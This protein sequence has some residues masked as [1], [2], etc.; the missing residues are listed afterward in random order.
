M[1][2]LTFVTGWFRRHGI[3]YLDMVL[4]ALE[5]AD[6]PNRLK[7]DP[8]PSGALVK[9]SDQYDLARSLGYMG[10]QG[11]KPLKALD[12]VVMLL[13]KSLKGLSEA[14]PEDFLSDAKWARLRGS[15]AK[16]GRDAEPLLEELR[17]TIE[18][19]R[20]FPSLAWFEKTWRG[21][22]R[23][24]WHVINEAP[25]QT[26]IDWYRKYSPLYLA[27]KSRVQFEYLDIPDVENPEAVTSAMYDWLERDGHGDRLLVNLW[28]TATAVQFGWY[29]LAWRR[30]ALVDAVFL[31]CWDDKSVKHARLAPITI[32]VVDK[33]PIGRLSVPVRRVT[34]ESDARLNAT[35]WLQFYLRQD[36]NFSIL[37]LGERGTGKSEAVGNAWKSTG[38]AGEVVVA[39]CANFSDATQA[40]S[41][42]FGHEKGAFTDA[43][44][45]RKG[46]LEQAD[47]GLLFLD[48]V[49]HLDRETRSMLLT[50]LQ[51]D[52][53]GRYS[54]T[55]LGGQ[56]SIHVRFQPVFASNCSRETL[57]RKLAP[58]FLDRIS[59][60]ILHWPSIAVGELAGVWTEVWDRMK[61]KGPGPKN[62]I[63]LDW[64]VPW[65]E[66]QRRPGNFRDLQRIAILVAD[67]QRAVIGAEA[68]MALVPSEWTLQTFLEE[69][70]REPSVPDGR[71]QFGEVGQSRKGEVSPGIVVPIDLGVADVT[72]KIYLD[73]CRSA[74]AKEVKVR[75]KTQKAAVEELRRRG[76]GMTESTLTKWTKNSRIRS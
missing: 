52:R 39:N 66:N 63:G 43:H 31:K 61:F 34:W 44:K 35:G 62:P 27:N 3:A 6:I 8:V 32:E 49:H 50:A 36:D 37:L 75:F 11:G 18:H 13:P 73:A 24:L 55:R 47:G 54:F 40:R 59:Q 48:E 57:A 71:K 67:Y 5:D 4:G 30:P 76:S 19:D 56:G 26:Q 22:E 14:R 25:L 21:R 33:D 51:T 17:R 69:R 20:T 2:Q 42:L 38:R 53:E 41:E 29:Y 72:E 12:R 10:D 23:L 64:F 16:E 74:F 70:L 65:L 7:L 1:G 15:L 58:D 60:R 46:L 45:E 68:E 28:G 9:G